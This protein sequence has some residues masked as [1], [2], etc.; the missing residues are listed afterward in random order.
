MSF[1][2]FCRG[3]INSRSQVSITIGCICCM[4]CR[5]VHNFS[6][7]LSLFKKYVFFVFSFSFFR[8]LMS[9]TV[10][11][12]APTSLTDRATFSQ[13]SFFFCLGADSGGKSQTRYYFCPLPPKSTPPP[14]ILIITFHWFLHVLLSPNEGTTASR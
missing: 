13:A 14:R 10:R 3:Y 4:I 8:F 12:S 1:N 11:L 2:L 5:L 9:A 6:N 7:S